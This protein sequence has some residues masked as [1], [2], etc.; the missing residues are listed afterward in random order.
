MSAKHPFR[1][2]KNWWLPYREKI[3]F[4]L[5]IALFFL[6]SPRRETQGVVIALSDF[7]PLKQESLPIPTPAPY[8]VNLKTKTPPEISAQAI[9][10]IDVDSGVTMYQKNES[11]PLPPASTTKI[12][13][14]LIVLDLY[15][16]SDIV[17]VPEA[18]V[19]GQ[20]MKLTAGERMTVENLL[21]G[22]LVYS[23]ND[24]ALTL[25]AYHPGGVSAFVD[26]MNQKAKELNLEQTTF[27]NPIGLDD[28]RQ[29]MSARDLA[30]LS[31]FAIQNPLIAKMVAIPEIT[32][33]DADYKNFYDLK[34][35]NQLLGKIPGVAGIK[36]GWTEEAGEN[37]V[38]LINRDGHKI[39]IV[40]LHSKDRFGD[41]TKLI[42]WVFGNYQW[43]KYGS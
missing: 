41:Q 37:L 39:I 20:L 7:Y 1:S 3:L 6:I 23:G 35:V 2:K 25:A 11:V 26:L 18:T 43:V 24:A 33:S 29:R 22:M 36:T 38:T 13:T 34:N 14:A 32:I 4:L 28:P 5:F 19:D 30:R 31:R 10:I 12:M 27:T 40:T 8:P 15:K 16:T 21:Y 42:D 9:S 17:T